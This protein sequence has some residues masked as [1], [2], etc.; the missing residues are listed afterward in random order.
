M[1]VNCTIYNITDIDHFNQGFEYGNTSN[2][3]KFV[4]YTFNG[5]TLLKANELIP[6]ENIIT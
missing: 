1:L 6:G 4:Y 3:I 2:K 5:F